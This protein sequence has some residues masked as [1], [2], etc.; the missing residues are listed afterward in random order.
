MIEILHILL[1]YQIPSRPLILDIL[2]D[3]TK[4]LYKINRTGGSIG[5]LS[6][7]SETISRLSNRVIHS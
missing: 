7:F 4:L 2:S 5:T 6:G 1:R 3:T